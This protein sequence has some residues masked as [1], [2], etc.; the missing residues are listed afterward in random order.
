M[1]THQPEKDPRSLEDPFVGHHLRSSRELVGGLD[2]F[3]STRLEVLRR[4]GIR[5][6]AKNVIVLWSLVAQPKLELGPS[7]LGKD[8][9]LS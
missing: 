6:G 3:F 9:F 2:C 8:P 7:D 5:S 1:K 4:S